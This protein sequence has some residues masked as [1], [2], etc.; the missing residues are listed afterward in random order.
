M[1]ARQL[2]NDLQSVHVATIDRPGNDLGTADVILKDVTYIASYSWTNAHNPVIVVP[3]SPPLWINKPVP[4]SLAPDKGMSFMDQNSSRMPSYPLLPLFRA[5]DTMQNNVSPISD[6]KTLDIITDRNNLRKLL[7][8]A[9][10][11]A[12]IKSRTK[13][14][15]D[16]QLAGQRTLLLQR[17]EERSKVKSDGFGYGHTFEQATTVPGPTCTHRGLTGYHR[18][19]SY[20]G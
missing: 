3:G 19:I 20:V 4:F 5:V 13:F 11:H 6:W 14:R 9:Y 17:W 18:I 12:Q 16:I 10:P 7:S 15:I 2:H 8:W 1:K